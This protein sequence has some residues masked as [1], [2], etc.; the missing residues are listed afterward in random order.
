[1]PPFC[2]HANVPVQFRLIVGIFLP[3]A[4]KYTYRLLLFAQVGPGP[5]MDVFLALLLSAVASPASRPT[6]AFHFAESTLPLRLST[7][8]GSPAIPGTLPSQLWNKS[9]WFVLPHSLFPFPNW[10]QILAFPDVCKNRLH[11][12]ILLPH[13]ELAGKSPTSRLLPP[14]ADEILTS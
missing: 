11:S 4:L 10:F 6:Q 3:D 13:R 7:V 14:S 1:M 8:A 12:L 2:L 5:K 9:A